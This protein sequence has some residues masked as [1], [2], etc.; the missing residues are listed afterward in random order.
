MTGNCRVWTSPWDAR[1]GNPEF[2]KILQDLNALRGDTPP[3]TVTLAAGLGVL[4]G[5]GATSSSL[6]RFGYPD[7]ALRLESSSSE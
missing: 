4:A 2:V 6:L 5:P 3:T 1:P 7:T